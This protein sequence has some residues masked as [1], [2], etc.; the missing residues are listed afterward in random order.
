M[1]Q[2]CDYFG[3]GQDFY[4]F[5]CLCD[6]PA[7]LSEG[8]R[9]HYSKAKNIYIEHHLILDLF[10]RTRRVCGLMRNV[11]FYILILMFFSS[12]SL[13]EKL[14]A[15]GTIKTILSQKHTLEHDHFL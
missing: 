10:Q 9:I 5:H 11:Y 6:M 1:I 8:V 2:T 15:L 3:Q 12:W 4:I 14:N 7:N 13:H